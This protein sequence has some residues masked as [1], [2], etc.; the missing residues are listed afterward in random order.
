M[1][2]V[3]TLLVLAAV[4]P[5]LVVAYVASRKRRK[6]GTSRSATG[7]TVGE[8]VAVQAETINGGVHV[9]AT[10]PPPQP[11]TGNAFADLVSALLAVP[12]VRDEAGRR[13]LLSRLRPEI[14]SSVPHQPRARLQVVELV[15]TCLHY[16]AGLD[17]L[18]RVL[19]EL[20]GDSIPVRRAA[21]ALAVFQKETTTS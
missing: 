3:D 12:C 15:H 4:V 1:T 11:R 8:S 19:R 17:D 20:E 5:L 6:R 14:S 13:L 2:R 10:M 7:D 9:Y 16:D 21:T 18:L